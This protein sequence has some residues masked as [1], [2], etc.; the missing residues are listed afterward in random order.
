MAEVKAPESPKKRLV[1]RLLLGAILTVIVVVIGLDNAY[2]QGAHFE[3][4]L[5][6]IVVLIVAV[7]VVEYAWRP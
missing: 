6:V 4:L 2:N 3:A 7:G 5:G 1:R